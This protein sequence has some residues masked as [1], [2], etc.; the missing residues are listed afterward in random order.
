MLRES[1]QK[2]LIAL[3][4]QDGQTQTE[5]MWSSRLG[6]STVLSNVRSLEAKGLLSIRKNPLSN[7]VS[8]TEKGGKIARFLSSIE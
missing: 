8:L 4:G 2:I 6:Y 7:V 3:H 5:L 1:E